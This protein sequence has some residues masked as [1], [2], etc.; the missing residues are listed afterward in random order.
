MNNRELAKDVED[1]I[2]GHGVGLDSYYIEQTPFSEVLRYKDHDGREFDLPIKTLNSL[3]RL[4]P[5]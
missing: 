5:D 1:F 3:M 2:H 4:S